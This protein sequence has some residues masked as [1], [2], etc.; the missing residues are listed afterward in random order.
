MVAGISPWHAC[1]MH[2][3]FC[4]VDYLSR[5]TRM[6]TYNLLY[7]VEC[8]LRYPLRKTKVHEFEQLVSR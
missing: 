1:Q 3:Y 7:G 8:G 5:A 4:N 6:Q 2:V